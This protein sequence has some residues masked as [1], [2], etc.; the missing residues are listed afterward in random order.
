M[1]STKWSLKEIKKDKDVKVFTIFSCGGG[2]SMGYKRAGF[3]V[4]GNCEIDKNI[5]EMYVKNHHPRYNYNMDVRDFL[6][7]DLPTELYDI[8]ILDG[9]PPCSTFS[10]A[11]DREKA[12]GKKKAFR[13]GQAKQRLDDLFFVYLDV[14]EK[15]RPKICVAENVIGLLNG[16]AK[17]YVNEIIK[18]FHEL[19]YE[20]QLFKLNAGFMEV[21]QVRERVFFIANRMGYKKL[22]LNFNYPVIRFGEIRSKNG[23]KV[24]SKDTKT[25]KLIQNIRNTD[26]SLADVNKRMYGS[27]SMFGHRIVKDEDVC[28]TLISGGGYIR[29]CDRTYFTRDDCVMVQSF[30]YDY[31]FNGQDPQYVCGMS[32]PPNM[33]A[34]IANQIWE[35]WLK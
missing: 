34:H 8:D 5:N 20:V 26:K 10:M 4:V 12:W 14:V 22:E 28:G 18:R 23:G 16:N 1:F 6:K 31:D 24:P 9:S 30:P 15:L 29:Y 2:S 32:V 7:Q 11:G 27:E 35:Q 21:P 17:G 19:G 3:D 13:E 25:Y 33:M